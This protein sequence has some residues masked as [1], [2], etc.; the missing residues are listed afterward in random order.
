MHG[1]GRYF[2]GV[3]SSLGGAAVRIPL[4]RV[5]CPHCQKTLTVLPHFLRP[6][7]PYTL[8]AHEGALVEYATG[9]QSQ[10]EVAQ[11]RDLE[12]RTFRRWVKALGKQH[13]AAL[14]GWLAERVLKFRPGL[15][16][17]GCYRDVRHRLAGLFRLARAYQAIVNGTGSVPALP[18]IHVSFQPLF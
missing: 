7:S 10:E 1:H 18:L 13:W 15:W 16:V 11:A 14:T 8:F 12:P 2:R 9:D 4:Y 17:T 3:K 5:R 6:Y